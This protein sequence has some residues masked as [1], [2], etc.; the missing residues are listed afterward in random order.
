MAVTGQWKPAGV[1]CG[2]LL[3]VCGD[4]DV[5]R[6][7]GRSSRTADDGR[8]SLR[9]HR[10]IRSVE[11]LAESRAQRRRIRR[12]GWAR[13]PLRTRDVASSDRQSPHRN[14]VLAHL[15]GATKA[16]LVQHRQ[17]PLR[18]CGNDGIV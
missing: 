5:A 7:A 1:D 17:T 3:A 11:S 2:V 9:H 6:F 15:L 16:G 18:D 13:N 4:V 12:L 14:G 8:R 10:Q